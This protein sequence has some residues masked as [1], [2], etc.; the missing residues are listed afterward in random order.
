MS[1]I[2]G[3]VRHDGRPIEPA[4]IERLAGFLAFRGPDGQSHWH[5]A[6]AALGHTW[7]RTSSDPTEPSAV[8]NLGRLRITADARIDARAELVAGL[9]AAG[10]SVDSRACDA[11]LILHAYRA[12]GTDCPARLIGDFAFAIWD[13]QRRQLFCARD[14]FGVKPLFYAAS[15][16][17]FVFG[18]TLAGVLSHRAV[19]RT[20]D[21]LA[22]ADYLLQEMNQDPGS[23]AYAAIRRLPPAH[24]LVATRERVEVRPYWSPPANLEIR[25]GDPRD[26]I[27]EFRALLDRA[28]ADR[29]RSSD[30]VVV[31]MSGGLDSPAVA[32]SALRHLRARGTEGG[33]RA[34]TAVYDELFADDERRYTGL[35]ATGLGIPVDF[36]AADHYSLFERRGELAHYFPE[37]I[38]N[39]VAALEVDLADRAAA[40]ARVA[41]TGWDGDTLLSESPRAYFR[42]LLKQRQ[43]GRLAYAGIRYALAERKVLPAGTLRKAAF[44]KAGS[45]DPPPF[46]PAWIAPDLVRR[47]RLDQRIVD[48]QPMRPSSHPVRPYAFRILDY[49]MRLSCF[50]EFYD[51]GRTRAHV[52]FRH[53]MM[54]LRVVEFC[55]ALPPYPWCAR[56]S[57][58]REALRGVVPEEVRRRPKTPLAGFPYFEI[59][60]REESRWVDCFAPCAET[61]AFVDRAK[62]PATWG[63]PDPDRVWINL[64][65]LGLDYWLRQR[66]E[67]AHAKGTR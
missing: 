58:L 21:E 59:L 47:H 56:K 5:D 11:L 36:H 46:V 28:T 26:Q 35:A 53:P 2:C 20:L 61:A 31:H 45:K 12:W 27:A 51:P 66:S 10:E 7:L 39:P 22:V 13:E 57:I 15:R 64:R 3:V 60:K 14:H 43:L 54:D 32:A 38:N 30:A 67:P 4:V 49:I 23:T 34:H 33:L 40:Q 25:H 6:H 48:L 37:P 8:T 19:D 41:L 17:E 62:I 18:N 42:T 44:W 55:L 9:R 52:E 1:G 65:P 29:V 16:G 50:Y 63:D 24:Y